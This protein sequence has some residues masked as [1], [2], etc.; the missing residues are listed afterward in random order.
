MAKNLQI[1]NVPESVHRVLRVRAAAQGRSLSDYL[2]GE[3]KQLCA[4][5]TME[6]WL[7]R[8]QRR[9]PVRTAL[10]STAVIREERERR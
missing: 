2:L 5:P 1:R 4:K 3:L 6:E 8:V 9:T 7:E 10:D